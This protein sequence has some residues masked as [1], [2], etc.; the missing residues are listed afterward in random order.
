MFQYHKKKT[1][2]P[3]RIFKI[4]K[5]TAFFGETFPSLPVLTE[6]FQYLYNNTEIID[7]FA[8]SELSTMSK[9]A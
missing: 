2:P 8:V 6:Y 7:I 9:R 5:K 1:F 3:G 4:F